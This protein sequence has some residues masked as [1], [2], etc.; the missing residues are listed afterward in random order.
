V[1]VDKSLRKIKALSM[2]REK[3]ESQD[4]TLKGDYFKI[5]NSRSGY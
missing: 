1:L 4:I 2:G 3:C 5:T